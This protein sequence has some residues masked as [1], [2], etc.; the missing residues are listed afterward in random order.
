MLQSAQALTTARLKGREEDSL[1]KFNILQVP[2]RLGE[3]WAVWSVGHFLSEIRAPRVSLATEPCLKLV[4]CT[5][6][7]FGS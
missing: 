7:W 6:C 1:D 3:G 5:L 2:G 4:I